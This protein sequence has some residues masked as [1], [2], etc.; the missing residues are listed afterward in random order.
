MRTDTPERVQT[1]DMPVTK[2]RTLRVDD[3]LWSEAQRIA[4]DRRETLSAVMK[5][6]LVEYVEQHGGKVER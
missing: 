1:S 5:R 4:A 6:A 3:R 2:V